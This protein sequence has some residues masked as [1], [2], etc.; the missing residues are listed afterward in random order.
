MKGGSIEAERRP[1]DKTNRDRKGFACKHILKA[2]DSFNQDFD[3]FRSEGK[4]L[5]R[6]RNLRV[7]HKYESKHIC[8]KSSWFVIDDGTFDLHIVTEDNLASA[9]NE[10]IRDMSDYALEQMEQSIIQ[11]RITDDLVWN[12]IRHYNHERMSAKS[13]MWITVYSVTDDVIDRWNR[14]GTDTID[15]DNPTAY[16]I[17]K[18]LFCDKDS[19]D[20]GLL[21][22]LRSTTPVLH[23]YIPALLLKDSRNDNNQ[24]IMV[25]LN[26]LTETLS[27][28]DTHD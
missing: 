18:A 22:L 16:Q 23:Q 19:G 6:K 12:L 21:D 8:K 10:V 24:I 27:L 20:Y 28:E 11:N 1:P 14:Y 17:R 7:Q 13:D 4:G 3:K 26:T 2:I 5:I 15:T 25:C 9:M